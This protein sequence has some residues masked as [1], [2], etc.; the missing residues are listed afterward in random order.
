MFH[1]A[2]SVTSSYQGMLVAISPE[3]WTAWR[4]AKPAAVA[5]RLLTLAGQIDPKQVAVSKRKFKGRQPKGYVDGNTARAHVA[6]ARVLAQA[7]P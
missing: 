2:L 1:L 7:R 6:T 3:P 5:D 4:D